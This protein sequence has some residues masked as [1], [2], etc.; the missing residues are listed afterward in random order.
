MN[1]LMFQ[2]VVCIS[3]A[4]IKVLSIRYYQR[5][6]NKALCFHVVHIAAL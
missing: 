4:H 6:F 2:Q 5:P 1:F 3:T